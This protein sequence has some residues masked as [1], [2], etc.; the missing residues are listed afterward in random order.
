MFGQRRVM[1]MYDGNAAHCVAAKVLT[2]CDPIPKK[3]NVFDFGWDGRLQEQRASQL[4]RRYELT[5]QK[6]DV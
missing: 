6:L 1:I 2:T 3:Q 5:A 4:R